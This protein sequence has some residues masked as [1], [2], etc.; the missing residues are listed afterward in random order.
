MCLLITLPILLVAQGEQFTFQWPTNTED[1]V[2]ISMSGVFSGLSFL[3][4]EAA[5]GRDPPGHVALARLAEVILVYAYQIWILKV[6]LSWLSVNAALIICACA[7]SAVYMQ[8][9]EDMTREEEHP[10]QPQWIN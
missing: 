6:G 7:A 4:L 5:F 1:I 9:Y 2:W 3:F 8:Q 10:Y